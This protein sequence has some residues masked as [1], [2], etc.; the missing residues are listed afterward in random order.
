MAKQINSQTFDMI[1]W[2]MHRNY[3]FPQPYPEGFMDLIYSII[4]KP[5]RLLYPRPDSETF[6]WERHHWAYYDGVNNIPYVLPIGVTFGRYPYIYTLIE[7]PPGMAFGN[8]TWNNSWNNLE[9]SLGPDLNDYGVLT[10]TPTTNV[11]NALVWVRVYDQ[12]GDHID[13]KF[14]VSTSNSN[15]IFIF[16]DQQ[17]ANANDN[18]AG[19]IDSPYLTINGAFGNT[20]SETINATKICYINTGSYVF[21]TYADASFVA[22]TFQ[23]ST[24]IKPSALIGYPN[25]NAFFD[26]LSMSNVSSGTT[27]GGDGFFAENLNFQNYNSNVD[28]Y[29]LFYVGGNR[30]TFHRLNWANAGYGNSSSNTAGNEND[31]MFHTGGG[32]NNYSQYVFMRGCQEFGRQ[33]GYPGNNYGFC[34]LYSIQNVLVE[35]NNCVSN[36]A[37]IDGCFY[38]KSSIGWGCM[39]HN[40]ASFSSYSGGGCLHAFDTGQDP[41]FLNQD[42]NS[43]TCF[44]RGININAI[45]LPD[46]PTTPIGAWFG[47]RNS[48]IGTKGLYSYS[49]NPYCIGPFI[50]LSNLVQTPASPSECPPPSY[51][52]FSIN[53]VIS[54][55]GL[56]DANCSVIPSEYQGLVGADIY[57]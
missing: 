51:N 12:S 43:E 35:H 53:N 16:I 36:T 13:A 29:K 33:N 47:Y 48:V 46:T 50:F 18:N 6:S 27:G 55:N 23:W 15:S 2:T 49:G 28:Q 30:M 38:F 32:S 31:S 54:A 11:S 42:N 44:N 3:T 34:S 20:Y 8:T 41:T 45:I 22:N 57:V 7:G 24:T 25:S 14:N 5:L 21:P 26:M 17:N 39:R 1:N 4:F 10:W 52:V 56:L 19:T 9:G 40:F 37:N